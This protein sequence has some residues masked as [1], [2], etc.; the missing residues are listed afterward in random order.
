LTLAHFSMDALDHFMKI[1]QP[2]QPG[3]LSG[4]DGG[5]TISQFYDEIERGL[6]ALC[7]FAGE[8]NVFYGDPS[9]Q[10]LDEHL[11]GGSGRIIPVDNLATAITA[12]KEIVEQGEGADHVQVWDGD[13]DMFH[14]ERDE[15]GHYYR[16]Q[17][18]Q[19]GRRYRRGDTPQSGPTG[20]A[21]SIDWNGVQPMQRNP[22]TAHHAPGSAIRTAQDAFNDAYCRLLHRLDG[23]FDGRPQGLADAIPIMFDLKAQA[24]TL[25]HL[26]TEDGL[27]TAGP[28][29]EYV[30]PEDR[31]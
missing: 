21:I 18:L 12:L 8:A 28:T 26:P 17:E 20:E 6:R 13:Q 27:T 23:A 25:M 15:V 30:V 19:L 10:V 16:F 31:H 11:Y 24:Q 22:R 29:F 3:A 1:E 5:A 9:R 2:V 7:A 4:N 14:P